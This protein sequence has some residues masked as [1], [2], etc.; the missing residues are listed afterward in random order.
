[1]NARLAGRGRNRAPEAPGIGSEVVTVERHDDRRRSSQRFVFDVDALEP[2]LAFLPTSAIPGWTAM[3]DEKRTEVFS[4]GPD[5]VAVEL[6]RGAHRLAFSWRMPTADRFVTILSPVV[7]V[8]VFGAWLLSV[9][10]VFALRRSLRR[11]HRGRT[12][13]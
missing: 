3:L 1:M 12:V 11:T 2:T 6:P 7:A 4:A 5:L 9:L 8:V 13:P 10:G